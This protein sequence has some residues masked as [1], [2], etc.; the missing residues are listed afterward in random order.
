M[1]IVNESITENLDISTV[2][3]IYIYTVSEIMLIVFDV[4]LENI[5]GSYDYDVKFYVDSALVLPTRSIS[6]PA[7]VSKASIQ[8]RSLIVRAGS[9]LSLTAEGAPSDTNIK[10]TVNLID[11][12]PISADDVMNVINPVLEDAIETGLA[13]TEIRPTRTILGPCRTYECD[14]DD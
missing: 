6:C 2:K 12:T 8:S 9:V 10:V 5:V 4:V 1:K 7:G 14:D 3:N 13:E 11:V